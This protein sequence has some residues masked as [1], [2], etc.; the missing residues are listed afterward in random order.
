MNAV[1]G[2]I[3]RMLRRLVGEDVEL[4]FVNDPGLGRVTADP[5]QLDQV[6]DKPRSSTRETRCPPAE[7]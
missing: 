2:G 5:G 6:L 3:A 1:I 7:N 4:S